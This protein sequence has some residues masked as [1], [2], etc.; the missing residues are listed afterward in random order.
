[1]ITDALIVPADANADADNTG[2]APFAG[3]VPSGFV[4]NTI[5]TGP[6]FIGNLFNSPTVSA[7]RDG[8]AGLVTNEYSLVLSATTGTNL[9]VTDVAG[10]TLATWTAAQL[11][12]TLTQTNT[13]TITGT[14][15]NG[16]LTFTA[17]T[18]VVDPATGQ[19]TFNQHLPV[20]HVD[21][22]NDH[23]D[24]DALQ[25]DAGTIAIVQ[26]VSVTDG[27]TDTATDSASV[28]IATNNGS[29]FAIEDDGIE[30]DA[31]PDGQPVVPTLT[32]D[33]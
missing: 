15:S 5:A 16:V 7:G 22:A 25:L 9:T 32:L 19:I 6:G 12:I 20:E 1:M 14:I 23:D 4:I 13:T 2:Q 27:D 10:T 26:E 29:M 17:L 28:V 30:V 3:G 11:E 31:S 18:I 8:Q 24:T 21:G 33:E